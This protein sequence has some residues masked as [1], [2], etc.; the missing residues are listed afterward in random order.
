MYLAE[1]NHSSR[2]GKLRFRVILSCLIFLFILSLINIY[3]QD[4]AGVN[5]YYATGDSPFPTRA[6]H[7]SIVYNN[8][9]WVIGGYSYSS[10]HIYM[11]DVW[12]SS[13]GATWAQANVSED[14]PSRVGHTSVVYDN[15]MWVIGGWSGHGVYRNDVWYST[16]G[17]VWIQATASAAFPVRHGH[18]SVVYKDKMWVIGGYSYSESNSTYLNDVWYS[19]DGITW[20]QATASAGFSTRNCHTSIVNDDKIWVIGGYSSSGTYL[21]DV[22]YSSDGVNWTQATATAAFSKRCAHTSIVYNN[23]MWVI[24]GYYYSYGY[25]ICNNDVWY[26]TDGITWIQTTDSTDFIRRCYHTNVVYNNKMWIIGGRSSSGS[27]DTYMN[28]V[29]YSSDSI[30]W[31]KTISPV[32]FPAREGHISLAY[33]NKIWV[34]GGFYN[35]SVYMNDVWCSTDGF[36]WAQV[37]SS[38]AFSRRRGLTGVIFDNK[39]WVIGGYSSVGSS[40]TYMNDVWYSTD[41]VTWTQATT[42]ADFPARYGHTSVVYNDKMWVIGGCSGSSVYRNDVWYSSDGV[43]WIKATDNA[44]FYPRANHTSVVYNDKIWVMG[45]YYGGEYMSD[46]WYSS[47]G[48]IWIQAEEFAAFRGLSAHTSLVYND[49]MWIIG[50]YSYN[51][52]KNDIWYST[53]GVRWNQTIT[54]VSFPTRRYHTS[55]VFNNKMWVT[56]G[57]SW[58]SGVRNDVWYSPAFTN[59]DELTF[60]L[61]E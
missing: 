41:G 56:G 8:K 4:D 44:E 43:T 49:K 34:I 24:G 36:M 27:F 15:K 53:D 38:A 3:P 35:N 39:M 21:N 60:K 5:W 51:G 7:T 37:T 40:Q 6:Q 18:T 26:S 54:G 29:W 58:P 46:V 61:Y 19:S 13:D 11:N 12:Y 2:K 31:T 28:D 47:D 59:V 23:K 14:F 17:I 32:S 10:A 55:L 30:I 42:S 50:G 9:M 22:W 48:V 45:G 52:Y 16:N 20:T 1:Y 25:D 57:Y 33:D